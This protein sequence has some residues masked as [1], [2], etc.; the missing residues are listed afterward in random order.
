[1]PIRP[2]NKARYPRDWPAIRER[3]LQRAQMRCEHPGCGARQYDVG[4]WGAWGG[5]PLQWF[6]IERN[7]PNYSLAR[8][9]AAERHFDRYGDGPAPAPAGEHKIIVIVLTIAHLN[10]QPEDCRP[11]NLAAMCQRHHLAH[12]AEHHKRTAYATRKA[13]ALTAD[14]FSTSQPAS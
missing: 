7:L 14:L 11:E 12:D 9:I 8:Q 10:H 4:Y 3:I 5:G 13:A 2:E 1:M 6:E